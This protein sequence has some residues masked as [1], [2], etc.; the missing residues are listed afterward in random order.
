MKKKIQVF[1]LG[2]CCLDYIGKIE[3]YPPEDSKCEFSNLKIQGGGPVANALVA[4]SRWGISCSFCG[5]VGDDA[6]GAQIKDSLDGEGVHTKNLLVRKGFDS[7]FAFI[8]AGGDNGKRTIFWRRPTGAPPQPQEIDTDL[9]KDVSIFHTDGLFMEA[10]LVAVKFAE[11]RGIPV[12]VD[13]GTLRDG[14][15]ELAE[16]SDF[17]I[18]STKF[19]RQL[20]GKDDPEKA[21]LKL[22]EMGPKVIGITLG[23]EGYVVFFDGKIIRRPAYKVKAIDTTGCGDVFHAGFIY[24]TLQRW[25]A[26]KCFDFAAWAAAQVGTRLG[27]RDGIPAVADW[28]KV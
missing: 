8:V 14:M 17:F 3:A 19:A 2:Q 16:R 12:S 20:V 1:G 24:G 26:E 4:L 9:L 22:V 21:C 6:F 10:S 13:A 15:L 28:E 25:P 7:Q 23:S 27:G 11:S 18:T 5:V